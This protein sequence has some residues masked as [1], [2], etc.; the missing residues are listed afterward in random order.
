[1]VP[2]WGTLSL[3]HMS[4]KGVAVIPEI[5]PGQTSASCISCSWMYQDRAAVCHVWVWAIAWLLWLSRL[6]GS[7]GA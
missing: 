5:R 7:V 2:S 3:V 1:M 4:A 6:Q